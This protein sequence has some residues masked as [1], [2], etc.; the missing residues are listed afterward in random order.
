V[1]AERGGC[2]LNSLQALRL[3]HSHHVCMLLLCLLQ[4]SHG[5]GQPAQSGGGLS[6][7]ADALRNTRAGFLRR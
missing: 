3:G 4:D 7:L 1:G 5:V 2:G 6:S